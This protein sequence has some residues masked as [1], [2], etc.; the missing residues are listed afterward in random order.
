MNI[1]RFW[2]RVKILI[3]AHKLSQ[4]D[5]AKRLGLSPSTFYG[6]MHHKRIPDLETALYMAASLGVSA[7]YLAFGKDGIVMQIRAQQAEERK[8]A[9]A[10][11]KKLNR[12]IRKELCRI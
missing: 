1:S 7:E 12:E 9:A 10:R 8:A 4:A 5:F 2:N 6:W 11:I 3:K